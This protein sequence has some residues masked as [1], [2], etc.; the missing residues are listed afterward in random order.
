[1]KGLRHIFLILTLLVGVSV[2][3]QYNP[4]NPAEPGTYYTLTLQATPADAGSFNLSTRT[5]YSAGTNISLR[6]Y[7]N[8][9]FIFTGWELDGEVISTSSSFTYMMPTKNVKLIA[10]YKYDPTNPAEPTEP[11]IP[12]YSTLSLSS[13]P[14]DGGSFN[15]S[16]GNRY[17]VGTSVSL[18]AYNNSDFTFKSW[19][20]NGEVISTS[21]SFNYV[22]AANNPKLIANYDYT[23]SNPGEP[24][25]AKTHYKLYLTSNPSGGGYFNI[26]SGNGYEEGESLYLC[27]YNNQWYTFQSWT[28]EQGEVVSTNSNFYY[29]MPWENKTLTA[30][31]TYNYNP[32]N[33]GDPDGSSSSEV[34]IYGMTESGVQGQTITYPIY[35][36][37]TVEVKEFK[38]D[39]Q[40]PQGFAVDLNDIRLAGRASGHEVEVTSLG[41][42]NYRFYLY[43]EDAFQGNNGKAFD[44]FVSIPDT[45]SM[46]KIYPIYLAHGVIYGTDG[47][48]TAVTVR[49]GNIFIE[50]ISEDGLYAK[51]SIDKMHGRVKFTNQSSDKAVSYHWDFGD[52]TT[53]DEKSPL[54]V[55]SRSGYYNVKLIVKGEVDEDVAEMT[56][57]INDEGTRKIEGAFF[58]SDEEIGVRYF[59]STE[60][61]LDFIA[62]AEIAGN[63]KVSI[64]ADSEYTYPLTDSNLSCLRTI[65]TNLMK[66]SYTLSFNKLGNGRNPVLTF[67]E[68]G[69]SIDKS[70]VDEFV[71]LGK[72]LNCDGVE[73]KMWGISFDPSQIHKFQNLTIHSGEKTVEVDFSRISSDL[74]FN[75]SLSMS[76][77]AVSGYEISGTRTIPSMTIVNEGVGDCD[78]VYDVTGIYNSVVFCEFTKTITVTPSLVG[79]FNNLSPADATVSESTNI[80]LSWNSITNAVYDVYLWN[81]VNQRP[82]MPTITG[83]SELRYV[84]QNFC[85]NGN[86]YKWQVVARNESQ[87]IA[88]DTMSFSIR[89]LPNLHVYDLDCSEPTAGQKFTVQWTVRNDGLGSTGNAEW[90]DYV[91]L[92]TDIYAG[93]IPSGTSENNAKLLATVKNVKSLE[94]GESYHNSVDLTLDKRIYGNYYLI[95]ASDMYSVSDIQW[96]SIGGSVINPYNPSQ[97]GSTYK[98]LLATTSASYNKVYEQGESTTMSDNFFYKKIDINVSLLPDLQ[99]PSIT[100]KVIPLGSIHSESLDI[101][102]EARVPTPLT[103]AGIAH[104]DVF[105]S[106]KKV[107]VT[108]NI[109]NKGD[110]PTEET[111]WQNILYISHS[112][113]R[114]AE[115]LV[116]VASEN[117]PDLILQPEGTVK[118]EFT[119]YMPYDWFGDTYFHVHTDINDAVYEHANTVN[120]WG[121]SDKINV[122]LCP[123]ADFV[124]GSL[125]VPKTITSAT[126]FIVKYGVKNRGAGIPYVSV[127]KDKIYISKSNKGLDESAILLSSADQLG[128]FNYLAKGVSG[129]ANLLIPAEDYTYNGDNYEKNV[130]IG[131]QTLADGTYYIYVQVDAN[132]HVYEHNGENNNIICSGAISVKRLVPD[133]SVELISISEDTLSTGREIA[134][135]WKLKNTGTG[136]IKDVKIKDTF[137]T[138]VNMDGSGGMQF[139]TVENNVWIAA[140]SEKTMH[141]NIK[142]PSNSNLNGLR[143]VYMRTNTGGSIQEVNSA[144]NVSGL[145]KSWFKYETAPVTTPTSRGTNLT[146]NNISVSRDLEP[147]NSVTLTYV[148]RNNGDTDMGDV[149]VEQEIFLSSDYAFAE[150]N[151]VKCEITGQKGSVKNLKAGGAATIS[152]TFTVPTDIIGGNRYLHLFADRANDL[153]EKK[154]DDNYA[155]T[156]VNISG[157]LPDLEVTDFTLPDTLM[158]S[159]NISLQLITKNDGE[160][161]AGKSTARIY[162]SAD[163]KYDYNDIALGSC[164]INPLDKGSSVSNTM[165]FSIADKNVGKWYVLVRSDADNSVSE[166]VENN[167]ITAIPVTVV[168][169]PLPDLAVASVTAAEELTTGQAIKI[170]TTIKNVGK[171]ATRSNKW[172]DTYYLSP[173]TVLNTKTATMIGS[174]AHVGAL[175]VNGSYTNEVSFTIPSTLQGNFMLFVVTDAGDAITEGDENNNANSIPVY[176][177]GSADTPSDIVI[178]SVNAPARIKAGEDFT[179]SY[180]LSNE[181]EFTAA[182]KLN[183]VIYLSKDSKWDLNDEMVGVVSGK[184]TINTGNTITRSVTGRIT[185]VPEGDYY[186][187]VKTNSTRSIAE[188]LDDNNTAVMTAPIKLVYSTITLGGSVDINTSGYYKLEIPDG[189]NGKSVGLYLTHPEES[190]VGLYLAYESVPSTAKY[191]FSASILMEGMQEV[192]IPNVETGNYY[193]LAQDNAALVN[194][195]GNVFSE[196]GTDVSVT[197]PMV[198]E[199]KEIH[200]GATTL[201]IKEGGNGGWVSTDVNGVL[202]DSIMDFRLKM[203]E[204]VIPAEAVTFNGMTK[205]R[206][207]FNLNDAE[208]GSYDLISELPDGTQATLPDGFKVVPGA[209]VGLGARIDAPSIVRVDSYAPISIS[210]ANGGNTDIEIYD[211]ILV[212]DNGY[213][214]TSIQDLERHQSV[215]SIDVGSESDSR[216]YK[217][218]PPGTKKTINLFMYQTTNLSNLTIYVVK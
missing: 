177:N 188:K 194:S 100:A 191:D 74:S 8:S 56:V 54:H 97:D 98:H 147:G 186:V 198:L 216:G 130:E 117:T 176:I 125:N 154:T 124:P 82:L 138:T 155:R 70:V 7:T 195:T 73:L 25:E 111:S 197:T 104:N 69:G 109:T 13:S 49:D 135:S 150:S 88:S 18:R 148:A 129:G 140:G 142:I 185:N 119:F 31:Y 81:A 14:S 64:I 72:N 218:I 214:G 153:G 201:S 32:T 164:T 136:D 160:W 9:N 203:D 199:A 158:T 105:Y 15:I 17:E 99:V 90:Y 30:N 85:Q 78:L 116:S 84:S 110:A 113:D 132:D 22:M 210:Y 93:T 167:N 43:G 80:T 34:H 42:N 3:G 126:S 40:F 118:V 37:N 62:S 183:D 38:V 157:N 4:T 41:E 128:Y 57:L 29:N 209:S 137:Y 59:T 19:T 179:I 6:A 61:L 163:S 12:V 143:Y 196:S 103:A 63:V 122:L 55:Y 95:V 174:K 145:L 52:G 89:S 172:S 170:K 106:G 168:P 120:N 50:N 36:E 68:S 144:N 108:A 161:E 193:I 53:S 91:W 76:P 92:V 65:Q 94:S 87:E 1:M 28:D 39:V 21:A 127:W 114:S 152:L 121:V 205:S 60:S 27:A 66:G 166:L 202:F 146:V 208:T 33:P 131:P 67:G 139:A 200:F 96:S 204:V 151:A 86:S 16:S 213:L 215:L 101:S 175:A 171:H 83:T 79:L 217:S 71:A 159:Q 46:G 149:E 156:T 26:S 102:N 123:G 173:S 11:D 133:L 141:A 112:K 51:F 107:T 35:L 180:K 10:H 75:W 169:S 58:L 182:G 162:L 165:T 5:S 23:P 47:S 190:A 187:I 207:T 178:S 115:E 184:V 212:L 181:G 77:A 48:Q 134:F 189:Y 24:S 206:V 192:L 211:L 44:L 45:A 20:E 2:R